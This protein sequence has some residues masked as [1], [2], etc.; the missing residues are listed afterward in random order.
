MEKR[1]RREGL[2]E[3]AAERFDLPGDVVAGLP[4]MEL[5]GDRQFRMENHQGILA[6]GTDE[7]HISGGKLIVKVR[8]EGLE[9]RAMKGVELL[10]TGRISG[11]DLT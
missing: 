2:L 6:Y 1:E 4:R 7:I 9:L 3:K 5:L 11:V 10:I 8:G